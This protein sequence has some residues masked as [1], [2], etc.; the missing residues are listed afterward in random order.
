MSKRD[1]DHVPLPAD[2][3]HGAGVWMLFLAGPT[4]WF[5]HFMLVYVLTEVLCKPFDGAPGASEV[6]LVSVLTIVA[7]IVFALAAATGAV[8]A[9]RR[10]RRWRL[11]ARGNDERA[12]TQGE[13]LVFAGFLLGML[14]SIAVVFTGAPAVVLQPC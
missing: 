14:F 12:S 10:W 4:I 1:E 11:A 7:T 9:H 8:L 2:Q 13:S 6:P 5:T 3:G